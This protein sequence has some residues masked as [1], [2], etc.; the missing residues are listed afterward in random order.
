MVVIKRRSIVMLLIV[1]VLSVKDIV[2]IEYFWLKNNGGRIVWLNKCKLSSIKVNLY[3]YL[4]SNYI[5]FEKLPWSSTL[6][7]NK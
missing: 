3:S 2:S 4:T 1:G 5:L 7:Q 6:Q